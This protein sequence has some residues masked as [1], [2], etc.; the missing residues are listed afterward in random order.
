MLC[1][2]CQAEVRD[3][4][5]FC[6]SCGTPIVP[7]PVEPPTLAEPPVPEPVA[8][9]V[10][11]PP[12]TAPLPPTAAAQPTYDASAYAAQQPA[13]D[14]SAYAAPVPPKKRK[15]GLIIAIVVIVLLL[16]CG[17]VVGGVLAF[18]PW[19]TTIEEVTGESPG[20]LPI[21]VTDPSLAEPAGYAT[22]DEAVAAA[23]ADQDLAD[24]VYQV[25]DDMG[26]AIVYWAGPPA[27]EYAAELT[28]SRKPDGTWGV[29]DIQG[30]DFGG[31]VSEGDLTPYD[32]AVD[33][34]GEH[35]YAVKQDRGM[36][37][38]SFT[39]DP[40]RSDP[41]SAQEAAGALASF[42]VTD[43][44]EQ[45]DGSYWVRTVQNWAG[46]QEKWEYWVVPT[47][48]GYSIADMRSW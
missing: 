11:L 30:L 23:L 46:G 15:T 12:P 16:L 34:V 45:S 37:A 24:W 29:V 38:Q 33:V 26:D 9:A 48:Q 47:E 22:A 25:Y 36:D 10:P 19:F 7:E 40:F 39:V 44:R 6:G 4:A 14:G 2:N 41:A 42:E 13:Y 8:P 27:S 3:G 1:P 20:G 43:A 35:L 28:V 18:I 32:Q 31:D 17:C 5:A 21:D